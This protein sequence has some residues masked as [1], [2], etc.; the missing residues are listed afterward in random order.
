MTTK[1]TF[2]HQIQRVFRWLGKA[3][4]QFRMI[5]HG[6]RILVGVSGAD[7]LCLLWAL[8]ERLQWIPV[9]Y[10]LKALYIDMGFKGDLGADLEGYLRKEGFDYEIIRS[11]IGPAAHVP[12]NG[13]N[14]CFLC[15]RARRKRLFEFARAQHCGKIALGHHLEDVNATLFLNIL[16]GGSLSTMLPRQDFFDGKLS[17]IRPFALLYREQ[18]QQLAGYLGLPS[19]VNPCPSSQTSERKAVNELLA[20]FYQKDRRI[21]YNIFQSMRHIH[22]EYLPR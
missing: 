11:D 18:I 4:D 14:P 1:R 8:R 13:K 16:Y 2:P 10:E 12:S 21:R 6:D 22:R 20:R 15:S 19:L 5:K 9:S 3:I 17:V 7:S